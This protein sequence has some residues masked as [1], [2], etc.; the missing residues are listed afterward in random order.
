MSLI[1][2]RH[3]VNPFVAGKSQPLTDQFLAVAS[4]KQTKLMTTKGIKALPSVC[5]SIPAFPVLSADELMQCEPIVRRMMQSTQE[6][7]IRDMYTENPA[8]TSVADDEIDFT[9][10]MEYLQAEAVGGKLTKE[11]LG[12]WYDLVL[13]DV[14][15]AVTLDRL[16]GQQFSA[17]KS[18]AVVAQTVLKYRDLVTPLSS[19][20]F[21]LDDRDAKTVLMFL[22]MVDSADDVDGIGGKLQK[23]VQKMMQPA[24]KVA[25]PDALDLTPA[26]A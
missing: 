1:S 9:A 21:K 10:C 3:N 11:K 18:A 15:R 25:Q 17:E 19:G 5:V 20:A 2:T 26:D 7:I 8:L 23:R 6:N 22:G 14:V 16:E 24:V 4:F 13:A 12:N